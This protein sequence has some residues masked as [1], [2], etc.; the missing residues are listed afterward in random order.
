MDKLLENLLPLLG[1]ALFAIF[2]GWLKKRTGQGETSL[3]SPSLPESGQRPGPGRQSAPKPT[4]W[5]EELRRLFEGDEAPTAPPPVARPVN[6]PPLPSP[7]PPLVS[8]PVPAP[9][10]APPPDFAPLPTPV[11]PNPLTVVLPTVEAR[12]DQAAASQDRAHQLGVHV[13]E[14]MH[15]ALSEAKLPPPRGLKPVSQE[16]RKAAD[17]LRQPSTL[18]QSVIVSLILSPPKG[19]E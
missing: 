14:Y 8:R 15:S 3:P 10:P 12:L 4:D 19:L 18:R 9:I 6:L 2:S 1:L 11:F 13:A 16:G 17:L 5:E 7:E